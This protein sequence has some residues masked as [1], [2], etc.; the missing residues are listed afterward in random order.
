MANDF[1]FE[2]GCEELPSGAVSV[3]AEAL[4]TNLVAVLEK[5]Q[6]SYGELR[7]FATPRRLAVFISNLQDEQPSQSLTRRGPALVAAYDANGQPTPALLGFAKSCKVAVSDLTVAKTDKGEWLVYESLSQG[8][9]TRDLLAAMIN[10]ALST[11]PIPKPM[12]WGMGDAEFARPV[13]W[14][15]LLYG[16]ELID[17]E[18]LGVKTGR[19]SY[20]HRF[21]HPQAIEITKA[22]NYEALLKEAYV[23]ADFKARR[24]LIVE[25]VEGLAAQH[26]ARAVM[27]EA[28]V[29][30]VTSIVEWPQALIANF[31]KEFLDVPA[32]ALIASMQSH[33]K[34]FAL[35]NAEGQLLPHFITVANIVSSNPQQVVAGNE[36]V[37]RARLS[38]AAFFFHQDKKQPLSSHIPATEN[39][40][41]QDKLGSLKEKTTRVQAL[42]NFLEKPLQLDNQEASRAAELSKCDLMT[43][44]VGEFPELQGLMGYY[45]ARHDGE[46]T[47]VALALNEQYMPRFAGD[48]LPGS[49]LGLAL[50]LADRLDTLVGIFALGQK[51]SGVKDPFKLRRHALAVVRML[52]ATPTALKLSELIA[53]TQ[54]VYGGRIPAADLPL[55]E[56]KPFILERMQSYYQGLGFSVDQVLAVRARQDEWLYD[57]DKRIYALASFIKLAEASALSAACKRVNNILQQAGQSD[58]KA[59]TIN[60]SLLE[61]GAEKA[62][63]TH[64]QVMEKLLKPL[65]AQEDYGKILS[66][67]A[68]L[69]EPVDAFFEQVMVMVDEQAVKKNRLQLLARLQSLLQG[70]VDISLLVISQ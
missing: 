32:E 25:Q 27:P 61:E 54:R 2:L 57:F 12:R 38:D 56:L 14:A 29:D 60:E 24:A 45:Y 44:M 48:E 58:T 65:Y 37:M 1:L 40:V 7:S 11:L 23:L 9:K 52:V 53:E 34:C 8:A 55:A 28:L 17:C 6:I 63:F 35:Q 16:N 46:T 13:H 33:Q 21:H 59:E 69:R 19:K 51:P 20:G 47:N 39:V 66:Q 31:E 42:M 64:L 26:S 10:Q 43:G 3:L 15:L 50:S 30:E 49:R 67:L 70:V 5:A 22:E 62:L 36:K 41:F 4:A 18:I 68:S